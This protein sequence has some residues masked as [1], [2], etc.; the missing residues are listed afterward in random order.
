MGE[1]N[2]VLPIV[3]KPKKMKDKTLS[4]L[5]FVETVI[6]SILLVDMYFQD[7]SLQKYKDFVNSIDTT[8]LTIVEKDT[9]YQ[10]KTYT[11]TVPKYITR[12]KTKTDTLFKEN[13]T[14]PH[15]VELKGKTYSKTITDDNDTITYHAH[16]SGYDVDGQEYP[17]LDSIEFT[18]RRFNI[19]TN[20]TSTQ[21]VNVPK[22]RQFIT[23][24][25]SVTF[26]YDPFNKQWG[27]IVGLSLNFNVWNK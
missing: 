18:L 6:V 17:R 16:V 13:D 3:K 26:G 20:T 23:T 9:V 1:C 2:T 4:I 5:L 27:A 12:W 8:T 19:Q 21:V 15:L 11:D 7:K 10:T 14:I 24:S 25:P 22:K